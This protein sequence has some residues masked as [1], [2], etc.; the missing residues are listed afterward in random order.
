MAVVMENEKISIT[1]IYSNYK[2]SFHMPARKEKL[3]KHRKRRPHQHL[4]M[5]L[6]G[7]NSNEHLHFTA[8]KSSNFLSQSLF[9]NLNHFTSKVSTIPLLQNNYKYFSF[10]VCTNQKSVLQLRI[11]ELQ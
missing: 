10:V 3:H 7:D 1:I 5:P 2:T 11:V 8:M 4:I 6:W 9:A